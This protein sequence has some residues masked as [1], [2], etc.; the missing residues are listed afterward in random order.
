[1][2]LFFF[3]SGITYKPSMSFGQTLRLKGKRLLL[4]WIFYSFVIFGVDNIYSLMFHDFS[5]QFYIDRLVGLIYMRSSFYW[6]YNPLTQGNLLS[7][8]SPMWFLCTLF[9]AFIYMVCYERCK[10]KRLFVVGLFVLAVV[11]YHVPI[12]FPWG[13]ELAMMGALTM[14]TSKS[15]SKYLRSLAGGGNFRLLLICVISLVFYVIICFFNG[16]VNM[17]IRNYGNSGYLSVFLFFIIGVLYSSLTMTICMMAQKTIIMNCMAYLGKNSL[18][19]LCIH[20]FIQCYSIPVIKFL[21]PTFMMWPGLIKA[22]IFIV[23]VVIINACIQNI[24]SKNTNK[25]PLLKWI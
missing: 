23:V 1:M 14:I 3:T 7:T 9:C 22:I 12:Q 8:K 6:P 25:I 21:F 20:L 18:R 4:P 24:F 17:M 19:L 2:P 16:R 15:I 10:R 5:W 13:I 11:T